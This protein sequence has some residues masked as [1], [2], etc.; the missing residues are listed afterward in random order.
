MIANEAN[1]F[2]MD[3]QQKI[4]NQIAF[5]III[6]FGLIAAVVTSYIGAGIVSDF[7]SGETKLINEKYLVE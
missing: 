1:N 2:N 3:F 4:P 5:I 6:V 7:S